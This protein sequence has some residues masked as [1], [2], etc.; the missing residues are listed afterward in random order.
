M[1]GH[2]DPRLYVYGQSPVA[3]SDPVGM[4]NGRITGGADPANGI[5]KSFQLGKL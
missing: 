1:V 4:P 3:G 2:G 5:E